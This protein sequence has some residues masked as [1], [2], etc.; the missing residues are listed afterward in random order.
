MIETRAVQKDINQLSGK[1]ERLFNTTDEVL[2]KDAK[3]DEINKNVYKLFININS[4]YD[5]L[6]KTLDQSSQIERE[7]I[8]LEDQVRN[9]KLNANILKNIRI[10]GSRIILI[11]FFLK[12]EQGIAK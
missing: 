9:I 12:G 7:M 10:T 6:L 1:L 4:S 5:E 8:D 2:F 11:T 3:K